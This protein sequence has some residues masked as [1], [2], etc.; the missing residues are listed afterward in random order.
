MGG[1]E[2][3]SGSKRIERPRLAGALAIYHLDHQLN[4]LDAALGASQI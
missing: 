4:A 2:A 1:L 3:Y